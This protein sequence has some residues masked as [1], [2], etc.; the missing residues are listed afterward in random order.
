M[1]QPTK[2]KLYGAFFKKVQGTNFYT[3]FG[4]DRWQIIGGQPVEMFKDEKLLAAQK[5]NWTELDFTPE[6]VSFLSRKRGK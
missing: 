2:I 1:T 5:K 3:L 6:F 4:N